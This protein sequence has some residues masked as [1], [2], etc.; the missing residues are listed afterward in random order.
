MAAYRKIF[1]AAH[2]ARLSIGEPIHVLDT[3]SGISL[4]YTVIDE[5]YVLSLTGAPLDDGIIVQ[6]VGPDEVNQVAAC[7]LEDL[8]HRH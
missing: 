2:L 6:D 8:M 1:T 4:S 7:L 5:H 3:A